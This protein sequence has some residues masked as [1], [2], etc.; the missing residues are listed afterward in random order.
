MYYGYQMPVYSMPQQ[1]QFAVKSQQRNE[2]DEDE[3]EMNEILDFSEGESY[4]P[5]ELLHFMNYTMRED[6]SLLG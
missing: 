2:E 4:E 3:E 5:P 6:P 1:K